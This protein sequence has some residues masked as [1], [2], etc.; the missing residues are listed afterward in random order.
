MRYAITMEHHV[1]FQH[2]G[3][4]PSFLLID[5]EEQ[6]IVSKQILS[7]GDR[8]HGALADLLASA[9][10]SVLICGGIGQGARNALAEKGIQIIAG[11]SGNVDTIIDKLKDGTLKDD[12]SGNCNHHHEHEDGHDCGSHEGGCHH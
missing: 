1:V 4:C 6:T 3:K 10:V 11:Q 2:F 7:S 8:G 5:M 9:N 12:P